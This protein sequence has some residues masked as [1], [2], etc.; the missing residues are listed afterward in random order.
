MRTDDLIARLASD[1]RTPAGRLPP[2]SRRVLWWLTLSMAWIVVV[3]A[4][5]QVRPD[6]AARLSEPRWLL[7]ET[8]ALLTAVTA[9]TAALCAGVPGRPRWERWLPLFPLAVWLGALGLG[10]VQDWLVTGPEGV[11]LEPDWQCLQGIVFV[12][13][14]PGVVMAM[15]LRR[16]APLAPV[17]SLGFGGL[18]AAA[19][20]D[21]GLRLFHAQDAAL[22][23]L[24]WQVGTVALLSLISGAA[25]PRFIRWRH[26][27][28]R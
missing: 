17:V 27:K 25:G 4:L 14:I 24:V 12:G 5:M 26:L 15:M 18:A 6:L 10:C 3:V 28:T 11:A 20:A 2:P 13:F 23:V 8:A 16:V 9:A 7:E 22:M 19:L 1:V 21:V